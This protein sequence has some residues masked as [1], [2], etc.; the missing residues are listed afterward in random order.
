M[1]VVVVVAAS[2]ITG[3]VSTTSTRG[4]STGVGT[5]AIGCGCG[6]GCGCA[7][8]SVCLLDVP[9]PPTSAESISSGCFPF[10]LLRRSASTTFVVCLLSAP[11]RGGI[12][13]GLGFCS[14]ARGNA[15]KVTVVVSGRSYV[16][17]GAAGQIT[18]N[19]GISDGRHI[20]VVGAAAVVGRFT[21]GAFDGKSGR[22]GVSLMLAN[23]FTTV[24]RNG[25]NGGISTF[26]T[27]GKFT[28]GE[29]GAGANPVGT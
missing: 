12:V 19:P 9:S 18:L 13:Q 3:V 4:S 20:E 7:G 14:G 29:D 28:I 11:P 23:G 6:C 15:G 24:D 25:R 10:S 8:G 17:S 22:C 26:G 1:T 5:M 16:G 21:A 2:R 27:K